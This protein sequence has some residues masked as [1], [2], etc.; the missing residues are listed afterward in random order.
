MPLVAPIPLPGRLPV[1]RCTRHYDMEL[2]QGVDGEYLLFIEDARGRRFRYKFRDQPVAAGDWTTAWNDSLK[3]DAI[4]M[5]RLA[6][7]RFGCGVRWILHPDHRVMVLSRFG[8]R[9]ILL[10]PDE[11]V[12][13]RRLAWLFRLPESL[14]VAARQA[15][16]ERAKS[17]ARTEHDVSRNVST[18]A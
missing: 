3:T 4:Y 18:A 5:S 13:N 15:L 8:E 14:L 12:A 16:R 10:P 6:L 7:G 17:P 2:R 1:R 9:A 11:T